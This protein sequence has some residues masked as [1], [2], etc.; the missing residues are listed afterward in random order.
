MSNLLSILKPKN[1]FEK[2]KQQVYYE[3]LTWRIEGLHSI[4]VYDLYGA[5]I[6]LCNDMRLR[7]EIVEADKSEQQV[8]Y[9][10][11]FLNDKI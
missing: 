3:L 8:K 5:V 10:E 4:R 1:F 2:Q 11:V 9:I 7:Y 6:D